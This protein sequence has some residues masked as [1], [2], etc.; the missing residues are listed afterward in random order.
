MSETYDMVYLGKI[1]EFALVKVQK[2]SAPVSED[3]MMKTHQKL[4]NELGEISRAGDNSNVS[5]VI[6]TVKGLRFVLEQIQVWFLCLPS[7]DFVLLEY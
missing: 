1:L 3:E 5:F 4:M 2:L 6:A 7:L